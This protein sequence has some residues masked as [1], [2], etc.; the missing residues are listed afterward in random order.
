MKMRMEN[1]RELSPAVHCEITKEFMMK[2]ICSCTI[3]I[4]C[5]LKFTFDQGN[6]SRPALE[7]R[8]PWSLFSR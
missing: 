6:A 1:R 2:S 3:S 5:V 4:V 8:I 7:I